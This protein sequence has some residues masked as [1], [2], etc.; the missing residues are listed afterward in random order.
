MIIQ[1]NNIA[2]IDF[3][4]E[5]LA[6]LKYSDWLRKITFRFIDI[7]H[8]NYKKRIKLIKNLYKLIDAPGKRSRK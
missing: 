4:D 5:R 7:D 1:G 2:L 6:H 3:D 8:H